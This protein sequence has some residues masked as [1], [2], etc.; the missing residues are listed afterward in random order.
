MIRL[1][2][3]LVCVG[4]AL[5]GCSEAGEEPRA[6]GGTVPPSAEAPADTL[7]IGFVYKRGAPRDPEVL[8]TAA[9][10]R[11]G[12]EEARHAAAMFGRAVEWFQG[13]DPERL[14][15]EKRVQALVGGFGEEQC[16]EAA[17][18]AERRSVLYLNVACASDALRGDACNRFAFH[19]A[20]SE[21]MLADAARAAGVEGGRAAAWHDALERFGAGQLRDRFRARWR[22][23]LE[24]VGSQGWVGWLAVK[25][26]W[27]ST[28]RARTAEAPALVS[29]LENPSTQFD[30]HKGRPLSFRPWDHQLRQPLYV[31]APSGDVVEVPRADPGS[32][33]SS[34]E[35]LD[36]LGT[37]AGET[38]CRF[39][40]SR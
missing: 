17:E 30:G 26:L 13:D 29:Y 12:V 40:S 21:A 38:G 6:A 19:V 14:V 34:R 11:L 27:E 15:S 18:V 4:T 24:V 2:C 16:R 3:A 22:D 25:V 39:A 9:G 37:T 33:V 10:V 8:Q 28:L 36:R 7:R 32:E 20:P 23:S 35:L 31:A 5:A 1:V